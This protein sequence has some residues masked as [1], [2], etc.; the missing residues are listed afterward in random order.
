MFQIPPASLPKAH[1]LNPTGHE[2]AGAS[3][4]KSHIFYFVGNTLEYLF[5]YNHILSHV[6]NDHY[7]L[8]VVLRD[9]LMVRFQ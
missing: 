2:L 9:A 5:E 1:V 4:I 3:R 7:D 8:Q 6:I